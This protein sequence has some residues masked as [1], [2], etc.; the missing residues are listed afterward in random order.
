VLPDGLTAALAA[1]QRRTALLGAVLVSP[2]AVLDALQPASTA[3][4]AVAL[5]ARLAWVVSLVAG[6]ALLSGDAPRPK[7]AGALMSA[8]TAAAV[9]VI[10]AATGGP[11]SGYFAFLLALPFCILVLLPGQL[12]AASASGVGGVLAGALMLAHEGAPGPDLVRWAGTGCAATALAVYATHVGGALL[13]RELALARTRS[14][15]LAALAASERRRAAAERLATVGRLAAGVA[16]EI[17]NPLGFVKANIAYVQEHLGTGAAEADRPEALGALA[18]AAE[19]VERI[20]RIVADLRGF[21]REDAQQPCGTTAGEAVAE[22]LRLASLRTR[23]LAVRS[24]LPPGLPPVRICRQRLVQVLVNLVVNAADAIAEAQLPAP[25]RWVGISGRAEGG[26]LVL[27]VEDG[28]PGIPEAALPHLFE[29]FFTTKATG[30]GV[31]LGLALS[32][33]YVCAAGGALTGDNA[34]GGGAVFEVRLPT[35][36][37]APPCK[38]CGR[39][40]DAA[41][42]ATPCRVDAA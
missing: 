12:V 35:Q 38:S 25:R 14:D 24:A 13:A 9:I 19:G 17:N 42:A 30:A 31:G 40:A 22:A 5:L 16:H 37:G 1:H 29:P 11:R 2:F 4:T 36:A 6:A 28:G 15:A 33:E 23:G 7:L 20:R 10:V 34:P 39:G 41:A 32:R 21:C 27:R 18:D 3:A 8:T 26:E